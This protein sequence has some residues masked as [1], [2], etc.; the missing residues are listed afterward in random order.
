MSHPYS[1]MTACEIC[2]HLSDDCKEGVC[3]GCRDAYPDDYADLDAEGVMPVK[4]LTFAEQRQLALVESAT[5]RINAPKW[6]IC[7][8]CK[9]DSLKVGP[10]GAYC[11]RGDCE[12]EQNND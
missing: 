4:T 11:E 12:W 6:T 9:W 1:Y 3:K 10:H 7:P 5:Q 8:K 2:D